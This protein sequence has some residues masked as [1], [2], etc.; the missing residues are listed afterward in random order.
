MEINYLKYVE[1]NPVKWD[2]CINTSFNGIIYAYSWYLNI[3]S[4]EWDALVLG[5]YK[6]VMPLIHKKKFGVNHLYQPFFTQQLGVFSSQKLNSQLVEAF[7][8]KIPRKY[9]LIEINLNIFNKLNPIQGFKY[10]FRPT[11]QLDLINNYQQI[12]KS[13]SKNTQRNIKK[14]IKEKVSVI[15]AVT[16]NEFIKFA[17][18][19][20]TAKIQ[21]I[22]D[23]NFETLRM[24]TS[25]LLKYKTGE[26]YG[27]F[28]E[29]NELC[30]VALFATAHNKSIYLV[31]TSSEIGFENKSMFLLIDHFIKNNSE[32]N[33]TLDF[34]G[35]RIEGVARFYRSFGAKESKYPFITKNKLPFIFNLLRK[36]RLKIKNNKK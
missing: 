14:A 36:Y 28:S 29:N 31:G 2:K 20:L 4:D 6:A 24:L 7:L 33:T 15:T 16:V 21:N 34:E 8:K 3:V 23:Q 35:S 26:L 13:Y 10:E 12:Y 30:A 25:V 27:A 9:W 32:H 1:L 18:N 5:D 17:K 11:Y 22:T 19:N